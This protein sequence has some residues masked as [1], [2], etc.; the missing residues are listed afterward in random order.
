MISG[1]GMLSR[2]M[3]VLGAVFSYK[4]IKPSKMISR[5]PTIKVTKDGGNT[6]T[7]PSSVMRNIRR[8][9]LGK[10]RAAMPKHLQEMRIVRAIAKRA[11]KNQQRLAFVRRVTHTV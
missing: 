5:N 10:N 8:R 2:M 6:I 7:K 1:R 3:A 11:R 4:T 9:S